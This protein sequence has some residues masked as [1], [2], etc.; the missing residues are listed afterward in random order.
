MSGTWPCT[1][2]QLRD[3]RG[4]YGVNVAVTGYIGGIIRFKRES[5][6]IY[7]SSEEIILADGISRLCSRT[8]NAF[9]PLP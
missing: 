1:S 4:N 3:V 2:G 8:L 6:L 7:T 5:C 9:S